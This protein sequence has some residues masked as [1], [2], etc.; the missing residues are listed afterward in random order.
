[1]KC[2]NLVNLLVGLGL[3]LAL[4]VGIVSS[5]SPAWAQD[6]VVEGEQTIQ[7]DVGTGFTYQGRLVKNGSPVSGACDFQFSLWTD[8]WTG[9]QVG[10]T[11]TRGNV[12][13]DGGNFSVGLDFGGSAFEGDAR[14]L[15]IAVRCPAGS[16]SYT[17]LGGRVSLNPTPYA[18]SL[19]PGAVISSDTAGQLGAVFTV[20]DYYSGMLASTAIRAE[21]NQGTAVHGESL[22]G[23]GRGVEG[24]AASNGTG[25]RGE[26]YAGY[27]VYGEATANS[28][29]TYGVYGKANSVGGY[30]VY[31]ESPPAGGRGV[32]GY[33]ASGHGV[34]GKANPPDGYGIYSEGNAYVD[35]NLFWKPKTSYIA[36]ATS[37]FIPELYGDI[38]HVEYD[39]EGYYLKNE[40]TGNEWFTALV[41]LPHGA[42]VK[43]LRVGWRD[44]SDEEGTLYLKRRSMLNV[45]QGAETMAQVG[46][47]GSFGSIR[48]GVWSDDTIDGAAVQNDN[49]TYYL[50]VFLPSTSEDIKLYGVV[51]EYEIT[52]PY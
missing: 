2:K 30:G 17:S 51:I 15:Q 31:G 52:Q 38:G 1:M 14:Y 36:V 29:T 12:T 4:G 45:T 9:S 22:T 8:I 37:A 46:S 11:E 28:G 35:G 32:Y 3:V 27:G 26:S 25:V 44:G 39:N 21:T 20:E 49:F 47:V 41:Q 6:A 24:K 48:E 34:H 33:S 7:A 23:T 40:S 5:S 18:H 43:E 10:G 13:L 16:G 19:R 50:E 42:T